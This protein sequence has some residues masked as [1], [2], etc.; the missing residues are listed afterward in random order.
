MFGHPKSNEQY[1]TIHTSV[2][3]IPNIADHASCA[4]AA[5]CRR[6]R[7][8]TQKKE[9]LP[10]GDSP[11]VCQLFFGDGADSTYLTLLGPRHSVV[12]SSSNRG[13]WRTSG[14]AAP[15]S[16]PPGPALSV[17]HL[18]INDWTPEIIVGRFRGSKAQHHDCVASST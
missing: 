2:C 5:T 15:R 10:G 13:G 8:A 1:V 17:I 14:L 18:R 12:A 7:L 3:R 9:G 11:E 16:V 6:F 4:R